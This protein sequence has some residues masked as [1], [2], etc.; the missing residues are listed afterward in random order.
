MGVHKG[1][2]NAPH[3]V[4]GLPGGGTTGGFEFVQKPQFGHLVDGGLDLVDELGFVRAVGQEHAHQ[5]HHFVSREHQ[6][7]RMGVL[8]TACVE[9]GEFFAQQSQQQTHGEGQR[10]ACHQTGQ[11]GRGFVVGRFG[12]ALQ[13]GIALG[14]V[15]H[16]LKVQHRHVITHPRLQV[17][18]ARPLAFVCVAVEHAF[19]QVDQ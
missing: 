11:A 7:P 6:P 15:Q 16:Q 17:Q 13:E 2:E 5:L 19:E 12:A 18:Q 8:A 14:L 1:L 9:L 4:R 10:S 3:L